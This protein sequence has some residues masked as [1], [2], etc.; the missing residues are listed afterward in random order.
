M[1]RF[2]VRRILRIWPLYFAFL[3]SASVLA[4][5][6]VADESFPLKYLV[7]FVLLSGNWAFVGWGYPHSVSTPLWSVS[8]EEQFYLSWP[9]LMRRWAHHLAIVAFALLAVS[10]LTRLLLVLHGAIHPQIW[11][12]TW[13]ALTQLP[14][15]RSLLCALSGLDWPLPEVCASPFCSS[16]LLYSLPLDDMATSLGK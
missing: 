8:I 14:A 5:Y 10:F 3:V 6:V 15:A 2:Y 16:G 12:N 7:S 11:C 9:L 1:P 13:R 4:K